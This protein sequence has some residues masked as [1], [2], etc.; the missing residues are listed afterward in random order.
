MVDVAGGAFAGMAFD[1]GSL[2]NIFNAFSEWN[3]YMTS[4]ASRPS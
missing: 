1:L 4:V 2:E 3:P